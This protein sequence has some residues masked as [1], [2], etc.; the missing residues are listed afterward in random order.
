MPRSVARPGDAPARRARHLHRHR[1][2]AVGARHLDTEALEL[3]Q[4]LRV[5][6]PVPVVLPH[7]D[8]PDL[9]TDRLEERG[10]RRRPAVVGH[11]ERLGPQQVRGL[12][13]IG[14]GGQL[15]VPGQ[16]H[17]PILPRDT[18]HDGAVVQLAAGE[19]VR[20]P[21]RRA[22][23][24]DLEITHHRPLPRHRRPHRDTDVRGRGE[25]L[26]DRVE[27]VRHRPVP[28]RTHLDAA[29]H[30]GHAADVVEMR[31]GDHGHVERRSALGAQPTTR[32]RVLARVHEQPGGR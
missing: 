22:Q 32:R 1:P 28:Q 15:R 9:G 5:G 3:R 20:P 7:A 4:H 24:L 2:V 6:V 17:A 8:E 18:Q 27:V 26:L 11:G 10:I 12:Q 23:H 31:V 21:G 19:A 13:Q 29:Q 16:Q 14:L 30:L 25:H